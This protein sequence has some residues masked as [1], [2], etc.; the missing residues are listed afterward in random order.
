M[1]Q[2]GKLVHLLSKHGILVSADLSEEVLDGVPADTLAPRIIERYAELEGLKIADRT[3]VAK[4]ISDMQLEKAPVPAE[5][6]QAA[7]FRPF[8]ADVSAKYSISAKSTEIAGG[9]VDGFVTYFKDRLD[10]IKE[11][12]GDQRAGASGMVD[13][14]SALSSFSDG[15]EVTVVGMVSKR[16]TTKKGNIL[17]VI[18]DDSGEAK[19]MFMNGTSAAAKK[20]FESSRHI[21]DD[22]VLAVNG[23]ISGPFVIAKEVIWPDVPIK[24]RGQVEDDIGIAF[25]SDTH[26]GSKFFMER[27]LNSFIN[28]LNGHGDKK[29]IAGKIKYLVVGGDVVDGIGIYPGQDKSLTIL[30]IYEQYRIFIDMIKEVP[31][32]I[33]TFIIPGNHDAVQRAEPQ[34]A[35]TH[36]LLRDFKADNIH[37]IPNPS[38]LT[39]HGI[40]TL[41]YHG[42]SLDSIIRDIPGMSYASPELAMIEL[43]KRRHLSPIYGGNIIVP[44]R[45]D[46][47]VIDKI[48]HILHMGHLHKNGLANYHGVDILNSGT[49]QAMTDRQEAQGHIPTPCVLPVYEAKEKRF[50]TVNFSR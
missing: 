15:R 30:D 24:S 47:L 9:S 13:T 40:E 43:L 26:V 4:I 33:E 44:S 41:V 6:R 21:V 37:M 46:N 2:V 48:P 35:L 38:F 22:E 45:K 34:P 32:Y 42:T 19:V 36:E 49:W 27:N 29:E 50:T 1:N 3:S 39:L 18:E 16:I 8:A 17:T 31:D 11:L 28:W 7:D 20:L 5:Y 25:I 14:L 10:R 12:L 23:R